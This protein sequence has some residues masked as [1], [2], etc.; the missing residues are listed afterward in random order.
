MKKILCPTDFSAPAANAVAYAAKLAKKIGAD[1][2]LLHVNLLSELTA[3]EALL[4][5]EGGDEDAMRR[6]LEQECLEVTRVFKIGCYGEEARA[7]VSLAEEIERLATGYDLI[8]MGTNGE[9]D[10][11][12]YFFGSNTYRVIRKAA[13][14]V[15]LIPENCG[16]SEIQR[17]TFAFDYWRIVQIP[18]CQV[19]RFAKFLGAKLT[20]VQVME[21]SYSHD[22][23][24]ELQSQQEMIRDMHTEDLHIDFQT[25][26]NDNVVDGVNDIMSQDHA[27][28]LALC[29]QQGSF[30]KVFHSRIIRKVSAMANYPVF[31]FHK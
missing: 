26:Y 27:D 18:M 8:V 23:E 12:Q 17:I 24:L 11:S 15:L 30:R 7:V 25:V 16:Y 2:Y 9:D 28:V 21:N 29:I 6:Q 31:V 5:V 22:A 3:G 19:A 20:M 14:P 4:G 1:L 13:V 10:I